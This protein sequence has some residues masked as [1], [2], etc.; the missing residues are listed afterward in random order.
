MAVDGKGYG[1]I[2]KIGSFF[3]FGSQ[4]Y[5]GSI[6]DHGYTGPAEAIAITP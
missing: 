3:T 4:P 1:I 5:Y 6:V 2:T